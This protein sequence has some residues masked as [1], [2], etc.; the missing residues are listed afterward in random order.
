MQR[1][2]EENII[3]NNVKYYRKDESLNITQY[4]GEN[5]Q[6]HLQT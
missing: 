6:C 1:Y 3:M 5:I 4:N 2:N